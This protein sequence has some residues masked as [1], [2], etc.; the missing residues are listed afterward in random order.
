[1]NDTC[2]GVH[3]LFTSGPRRWLPAGAVRIVSAGED[4]WGGWGSNP[5]PTD[6]EKPGPVQLMHYLHGYHLAVP[7]I[8]LIAPFARVARSTNRSTPRQGDH[9]IQLQNVTADR[10]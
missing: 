5:R 8:A 1:V 9:R 7:L 10:A 4:R 6:Y 3:I 2:A